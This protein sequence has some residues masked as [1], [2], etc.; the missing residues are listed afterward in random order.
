MCIKRKKPPIRKIIVKKIKPSKE[1]FEASVKAGR[2]PYPFLYKKFFLKA[3]AY[4]I[5]IFIQ[6]CL[7]LLTFCAFVF[8]LWEGVEVYLERMFF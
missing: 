2:V 8:E 6:I 3:S 5:F 7:V 4:K 1:F